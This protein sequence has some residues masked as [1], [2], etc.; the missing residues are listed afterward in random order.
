MPNVASLFPTLRIAPGTALLAALLPAAF[1]GREAGSPRVDAIGAVIL[2]SAALKVFLAD[3]LPGI[4]T[5]P[6]TT[7]ANTSSGRKTTA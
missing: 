4:R 2:L 7:S 1:V 5:C 3:T 6:A